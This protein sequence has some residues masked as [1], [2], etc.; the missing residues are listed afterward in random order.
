MKRKNLEETERIRIALEKERSKV[1]QSASSNK[2]IIKN[3]PKQLQ[4]LADQ[5]GINLS[6]L[7]EKAKQI[8]RGARRPVQLTSKTSQIFSSIKI[9]GTPRRPTRENT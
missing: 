3:S 1:M 7:Q 9:G 6:E 5:L 8:S 4:K 2:D